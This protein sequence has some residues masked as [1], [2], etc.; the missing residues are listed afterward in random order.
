MIGI[1]CIKNN[2]NGKEY[3][4][5]SVNI[6][7]RITDHKSR[8]FSEGHNE[9][10]SPLH[11]AIRKYGWSNFIVAVEKECL[12][13]D[14]NYW[15]AYFIK[16]KNTVVKNGYNIS[17]GNFFITDGEVHYPVK[18]YRQTLCSCGTPMDIKAKQ[19]IECY[20]KEVRSNSP[21]YNINLFELIDKCLTNG[22]S[23]TG[24]ELGYTSGAPIIK[25][26]KKNQIPHSLNELFPYYEELTGNKH[27][28]EV[29]RLEAMASKKK[30][31]TPKPVKQFD[32]EGNYITTF[33][34]LYE[35]SKI[36]DVHSGHISECMVGKRKRAGNFIW[37]PFDEE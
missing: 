20:R 19:C 21:V 35:A 9:Y 23:Q 6:Q 2:I 3:I 24:R 30:R 29:K 4:G 25:F 28:V 13:E 26:F 14:L 34:S 5:Q 17:S 33:Q 1:Y 36:S 27:P 22:L 31:P 15:E 32:L 11:Q 18:T 7:R 16:T 8:A 37:K 10:N 12:P